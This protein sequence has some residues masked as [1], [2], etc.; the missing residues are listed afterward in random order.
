MFTRAS[1]ILVY[2]A[3]LATAPAQTGMRDRY[4][5]RYPFDAWK[6]EKARPQIR[7]S[8][9]IL[10]ARLS[11]HQRL[12]ARIEIG[13]DRHEI[14]KRRGR[15]AIVIFVEI[16]DAG[17][18]QWRT[19]Q[20]VDLSHIPK[21]AKTQGL[22]YAQEAFVLPGE[23]KISLAVCDS[24]TLEHSF[25]ERTFR[26]SALRDDPLPGA[27]R[28]LPAVEFVRLFGAPDVWF[29]PYVR[30]RLLLPLA[31]SRPLHVDLIMN[32]T[33]SERVSASIRT[34]RRNMSVL[35]P[36][37]KMLSGIEPRNGSL[38]V[39]LL[40]LTRRRA[41]EQKNAH[42]LD[43]TRLRE[44]LAGNSPGVIDAQSLA[45]RAEMRQFFW[46]QV[47][48]RLQNEHEPLRVVI[49]LSAP[50]FLERQYKVEPAALPKDS[51]RRVYYLRYRP[52]PLVRTVF[53]PFT[54]VPRPAA[55]SLP[56]DDFENTLKPLDARV[57]GAITPQDF[58]KAVANMLAEISRM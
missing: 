27:W 22:T 46:D 31:A 21:D 34:F 51:N 55:N 15:G 53:N 38:D 29:Q 17:G 36:A 57:L 48:G 32:L 45:A 37:L 58:R 41:W 4:F 1:A 33:P 10:P 11:P 43:W 47:T 40:D 18:R 24:Q 9:K 2:V 20:S 14:E 42:G 12:A 23:Y 19:H 3:T 49:V 30:G 50:V 26:A 56:S 35:V 28:D 8:D 13:L 39:T 5:L 54:D 25:V 52:L 6:T 7:W 16:E 44:P